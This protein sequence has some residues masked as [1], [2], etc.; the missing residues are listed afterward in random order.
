MNTPQPPVAAAYAVAQPVVAT[1]Q[2]Q[3][4]VVAPAG[5]AVTAPMAVATESKTTTTTATTTTSNIAN[6]TAYATQAGIP[7]AQAMPSAPPMAQLADQYSGFKAQGIE[8]SKPS[9][10]EAGAEA[11]DIPAAVDAN[12]FSAQELT[13]LQ[14][15]PA[16]RDTFNLASSTAGVWL[17]PLNKDLKKIS[18]TILF[19]SGALRVLVRVA[20][21]LFLSPL[22]SFSFLIP[23]PPP[24]PLFPL[25]S[26]CCS[27]SRGSLP[28]K[29]GGSGALPVPQDAVATA[30]QPAAATAMAITTAVGVPIAKKPVPSPAAT[31]YDDDDTGNGW[32]GI[33]SGDPCLSTTPEVLRFLNTYNT[34]PRLACRVWGHH[35]E[36]R[37]RT[38]TERDSDGK[39][40]RD[41]DGNTRTR[42]ETYYVTV[43]D[44]DYSIDMTRFIFPYGYIQSS[45]K[46]KTVPEV[47]E[48]YLGDSNK[49]ATL[50]MKKVIGFD[51][52]SLKA[53]VYGYIRSLGWRRGL[54][55]YFPRRNYSVRVYKSNCLSTM[56]ENPCCSILCHLTIIPC[57]VMRCYRDCGGHKK[58]GIRSY[59]KINYHAL[60]VFEMIKPTLWCTGYDNAQ[61]IAEMY[62]NLF[63]ERPVN[64]NVKLKKAKK[65]KSKKKGGGGR[66]KKG[67]IRSSR[68]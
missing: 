31:E 34:R 24:P 27:S 45:D 1:A 42:T 52:R 65:K 37:H 20:L 22:L 50:E 14:G 60:Q 67:S 68:S 51:F 7:V 40:K 28:P 54:N 59:F 48:E 25:S 12:F 64:R 15:V 49:L 23:P 21:L 57:I 47:I 4:V 43:T 36:R 13:A 26:S 61:M 33:K 32:K 55:I 53:M 46:G 8:E 2:V 35:Q 66:K 39:P 29:N 44:F 62:R 56:W 17:L 6:I 63:W 9:A 41:S 18:R 10:K 11:M 30:A 19:D 38:V 58:T 3:P 16:P 5:A